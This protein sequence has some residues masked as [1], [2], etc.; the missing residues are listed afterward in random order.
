MNSAFHWKGQPSIFLAHH[1]FWTNLYRSYRT[2]CNEV[3]NPPTWKKFCAERAK[4]LT[5]RQRRQER[6]NATRENQEAT[7]GVFVGH[8]SYVKES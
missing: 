8:R 3:R 5:K 4:E 2:R 6:L 7:L 1:S